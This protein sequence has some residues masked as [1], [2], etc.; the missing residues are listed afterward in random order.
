MK[1]LTIK[2]SNKQKNKLLLIA[3]LSMCATFGV[4]FLMQ[5]SDILI[6]SISLFATTISAANFYK[7]FS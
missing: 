4:L 3:S 2:M 7:M 1:T 6:K 5:Q